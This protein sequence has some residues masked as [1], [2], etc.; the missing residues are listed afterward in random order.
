VP[1]PRK[2]P[3]TSPRRVQRARLSCALRPQSSVRRRLCLSAVRSREEE[4][5]KHQ[6]E[7][8]AP[9]CSPGRPDGRARAAFPVS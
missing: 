6:G 2:D 8:A 7:A 5:D 9:G 4:D 3:G 1:V